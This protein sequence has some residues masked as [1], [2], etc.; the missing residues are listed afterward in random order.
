MRTEQSDAGRAW[1]RPVVRAAGRDGRDGTGRDGARSGAGRCPV[2]AGPGGRRKRAGPGRAQPVRVPAGVPRS[3]GRAPPG[4]RDGSAPRPP[5]V[6]RA[7]SRSRGA[8]QSGSERLRAVLSFPARCPSRPVPSRSCWENRALVGVGRGSEVTARGCPPSPSGPPLTTRGRPAAPRGSAR[9]AAL[10]A[11]VSPTADGG[12]AGLRCGFRCPGTAG[13]ARTL[14]VRPLWEG[15]C[16]SVPA[17]S[18][19][20]VQPAAGQ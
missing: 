16:G 20:A 13:P 9:G 5:P 1:G 4:G 2:G 15:R 14:C 11:A 19:S 3:S 6:P 8:R 17:V 12:C 10:T 7:P 18:P